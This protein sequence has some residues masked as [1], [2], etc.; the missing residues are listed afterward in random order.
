MLFLLAAL[1]LAAP[2]AVAVDPPGD[3]AHPAALTDFV[4]QTHGSGI[5][6]VLYT[7][8]G[9]GAHPVLLLFHG[10]PGNE[11][12]LDL[13]QAARRAGWH[14][15]T[16][17]YRGSWGSH[18]D[19][20]FAHCVEDGQAA[21]DWL[22]A[23]ANVAK[24]GIDP[25]RIVV[26]GHSMGGFVAVETAA[27]NPGLAG[28]ALIDAWNI[29]N[30]AGDMARDRTGAAAFMASD[31]APLTGTSPA[32]LVDEAIA[33]RTTWELTASAAA[34]ARHP[35]FIAGATRGGAADNSALA[36]AVAARP[37]A[38]V[39]AVTMPTDHSFSDHRIALAGAL[40]DWLGT[41]R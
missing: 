40:V 27:A 22:R 33:H 11:Q 12:N 34:L 32:A 19:F 4:L 38:H 15:L 25:K 21:L 41:V 18:G 35:L 3:A 6:A 28:V 24:Y 5:N 1:L 37:G 14:V 30:S 26:A 17:H 39:T 23:P 36:A 10:F 9:A 13:A 8:S 7:A 2:A 16:L 29:G 31:S 20:S